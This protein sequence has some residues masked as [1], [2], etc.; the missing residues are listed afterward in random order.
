MRSDIAEST[1][2]RK[3]WMCGWWRTRH[4]ERQQLGRPHAMGL[5][6][7][8]ANVRRRQVEP[9]EIEAARFEPVQEQRDGILGVRWPVVR[10]LGGRH[11]GAVVE[12][13]ADLCVMARQGV[14]ADI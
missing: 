5:E 10:Q 9:V 8:R 7:K 6:S 12:L 1:E 4:A 11:A 3:A 2:R 14:V 13:L